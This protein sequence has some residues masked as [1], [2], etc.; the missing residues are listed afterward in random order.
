M[1]DAIM[2]GYRYY[3][4]DDPRGKGKIEGYT[5]FLLQPIKGSENKGYMPVTF[6][7]RFQ[8]SMKFPT[9]SAAFFKEKGLEKFK[10]NE[11]VKVLFDRNN[12]IID[13]VKAGA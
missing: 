2:T 11:Y 13:L 7:N 6:F 3:Q 12:K 5:I 4:F 10:T 1:E 9:V 8:N